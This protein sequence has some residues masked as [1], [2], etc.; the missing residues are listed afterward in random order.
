MA[1]TFHPFLCL[2]G[3][4]RARIWELNRRASH[5]RGACSLS[6]TKLYQCRGDRAKSHM[7]TAG[8]LLVLAYPQPQPSC[9]L[10]ARAMDIPIH[11]PMLYID[12]RR[13][14]PSSLR[15]FIPGPTLRP[16]VARG[17]SAMSDSTSM[18]ISSPLG[19]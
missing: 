1:A 3:K 7:A 10:V 6:S 4:P 5:R 2:A 11:A 15:H 19:R 14:F 13:P 9:I 16:R 12:W 8:A 18:M 17:R